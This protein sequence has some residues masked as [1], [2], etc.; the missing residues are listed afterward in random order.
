MP[1]QAEVCDECDRPLTADGRC[2]N[3]DCEAAQRVV[4]HGASRVTR[5]AAVAGA[6]G[7]DAPR[8]WRQTGGVD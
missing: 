6:V 5:K 8:A 3:P 7:A 4:S 2:V 1:Q